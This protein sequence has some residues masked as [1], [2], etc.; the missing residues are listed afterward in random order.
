MTHHTIRMINLIC[1][2]SYIFQ[3]SSYFL[4]RKSVYVRSDINLGNRNHVR[5]TIVQAEIVKRNIPVSNGVV[6]LI[7]RPLVKTATNLWGFLKKEVRSLLLLTFCI[8]KKE[9]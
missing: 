2:H 7:G 1:G 9:V 4:I 3:F 6:H 8:E 5:H